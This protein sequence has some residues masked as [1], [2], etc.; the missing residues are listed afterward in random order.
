MTSREGLIVTIVQIEMIVAM[1]RNL[2]AV[3]IVAIGFVAT[4]AL[5][6]SV[7]AIMLIMCGERGLAESPLVSAMPPPVRH[8][9][10]LAVRA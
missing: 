8:R 2:L 3:M 1:V 5:I 10:P 4:I 7:V 9:N 6:P